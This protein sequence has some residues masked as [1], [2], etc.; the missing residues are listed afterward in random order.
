[1]STPMHCKHFVANNIIKLS[2]ESIKLLVRNIFLMLSDGKTF[3]RDNG[4]Y[5]SKF[6][7]H[8]KNPLSLVAG[9]ELFCWDL[10]PEPS[11]R[12]GAQSCPL[13]DPGLTWGTPAQ[14]PLGSCST[15][16]GL[17]WTWKSFKKKGPRNRAKNRLWLLEREL[18]AAAG[19][20]ERAELI[21]TF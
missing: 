10:W 18:S 3:V 16:E 17:K 8:V 1:M 14:P 21:P 2:W 7:F 20:F 15:Q 6:E 11:G 5:I 4:R 9:E 12:A 19:V 13:S